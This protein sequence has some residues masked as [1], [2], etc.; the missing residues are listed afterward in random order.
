MLFFSMRLIKPYKKM[1]ALIIVY[2]VVISCVALSALQLFWNFRLEGTMPA[3]AVLAGSLCFIA[4]DTILAC[5]HFGTTPRFGNIL[6]MLP[7]M[8]AEAGLVLGIARL[9]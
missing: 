5:F 3:L 9:T 6:V 1:K 7:Y 2:S 4:S 8:A